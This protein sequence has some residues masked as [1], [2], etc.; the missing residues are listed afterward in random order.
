MS[1]PP[2]EPVAVITSLSHRARTS[3]PHT[4]YIIMSCPSNH[5][6]P[7]IVTIRCTDLERPSSSDGCPEC[8][9]S[10]RRSGHHPPHFVTVNN[11]WI[12]WAC[13]S[14]NV[15]NRK[16]PK[17]WSTCEWS[18]GYDIRDG[19]NILNFVTSKEMQ[20]ER[21]MSD[22]KEEE[23]RMETTMGTETRTNEVSLELEDGYWV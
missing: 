22:Y 5:I 13:G 20:E 2:A 9:S 19:G 4:Q 18:C 8:A 7:G 23:R 6:P 10:Y 11:G 16:W 15:F 1:D 21:F 14:L 17:L 3:N 12:C